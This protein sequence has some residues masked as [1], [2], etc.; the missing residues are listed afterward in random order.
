MK[1]K[2]AL[3]KMGVENNIYDIDEIK[4]IYNEYSKSGE[5]VS[6]F[7]EPNEEISFNTIE[8]A[9][10]GKV[11][12][13]DKVNP[14]AIEALNYFMSKGLTREQAAGLVGN[15]MRESSMNI[16]SLNPYSG[17]YGLGQ[18]L[19]GR[20]K[21]LISMY[22][23]NPTF[24]NQLDFTW[25]ELNS[26]HKN[27]L[28][29]IKQSKTVDEAAANAFGYYE[30]SSGP[31]AAVKAMNDAGMNTRWKNPNGTLALNGGI[32]QA[33]LLLGVNP[34]VT[35]NPTQNYNFE[36]TVAPALQPVQIKPIEIPELKFSDA[37]SL[38]TEN[39]EDNND[40][41]LLEQQLQKE[42]EEERK[43]QLLGIFNFLNQK[44]KTQKN[45][46]TN[47]YTIHI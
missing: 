38:A 10:G 11:N 2:A 40:E 14:K 4:N 26:S 23:N 46:Q 29:M 5:V 39:K 18:W 6:N 35:S 20:K 21:K 16:T 3:I 41:Q 17:A 37:S 12:K 31:Q 43:N 24:Q 34:T 1:Q 44:P 9:R 25:H 45:T 13:Q 47:K 30:F 15:F 22:G 8:Y 28:R 27:G 36:A 33:R 42:A 19:G 7:T 32:E